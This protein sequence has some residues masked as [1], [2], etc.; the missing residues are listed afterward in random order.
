MARGKSAPADV[1]CYC[2]MTLTMALDGVM[3]L[4][5]LKDVTN[6][7]KCMQHSPTIGGNSSVQWQKV[8][9]E[10]FKCVFVVYCLL[11]SK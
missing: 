5:P 1:I 11:E 10:A 3:L 8:E 4:L 7:S 6:T 9:S 2:K